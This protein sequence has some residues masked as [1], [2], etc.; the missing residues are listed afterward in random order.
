MRPSELSGILFELSR[1]TTINR[2]NEQI[3]KWAFLAE[4]IANGFGIL[5]SM[6]SGFGKR[7][8]N[9]KMIKAE[10]FISKDAKKMHQ[11][12]L[13]QKERQADWSKHVEDA[14]AKGLVGLG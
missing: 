1:Q 8:Y 3:N 2:Y 6:I 10:D 9:H 7:K 12:L 11:R 5:M 14:K 4:V 13:G